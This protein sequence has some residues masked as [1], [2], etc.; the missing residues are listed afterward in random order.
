MTIN[1]VDGQNL[2]QYIRSEIGR[3]NISKIKIPEYISNNLNKEKNII[4]IN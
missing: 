4:T 1:N 2:Q 3:K